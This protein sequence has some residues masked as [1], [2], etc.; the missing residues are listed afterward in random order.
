MQLLLG[1]G[2][3]S[4]TVESVIARVIAENV[5]TL[6]ELR[7]RALSKAQQYHIELMSR[8]KV[9]AAMESRISHQEDPAEIRH[10]QKELT[11]LKK[12]RDRSKNRRQTQQLII[13]SC[14]RDLVYVG[15]LDRP[16]APEGVSPDAPPSCE[17][18]CGVTVV[19]LGVP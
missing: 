14:E 16:T 9:V 1:P 3:C 4:L 2:T 8:M 13:D 18:P 7:K 5:E 11:S 6:V 15:E 10:L 19:A 12:R 17:V